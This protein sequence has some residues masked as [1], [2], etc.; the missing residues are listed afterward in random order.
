KVEELITKFAKTE[1]LLLLAIMVIGAVLSAF[2]SN[3]STTAVMMPIVL[4]IASTAGF[5]KSKLLMPLAYAT[6]FGGMI[7]LVG[8]NGNLAVQGVVENKGVEG[9]G[10]VEFAYVGMPLTLSHIIYMMKIGR[11]ACR[12]KV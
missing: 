6:A 1:K 3:T 10:F 7:T 5:S 4:V 2:L 11:A 8:T 9:I 12:E